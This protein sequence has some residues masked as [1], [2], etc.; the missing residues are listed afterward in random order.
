VKKRRALPWEKRPIGA[1]VAHLAGLAY[2][3][4]EQSVINTSAS[5]IDLDEFPLPYRKLTE[6]Y[7]KKYFCGWM[8]PLATV[9]TSKGCP[10]R[11]SFCAL[12]KIS[13]GK[14]FQRKP[15][16]IVEEL[17]TIEEEFI[18]FS[19]DESMVNAS[20]WSARRWC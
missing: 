19:D 17:S 11:C 10:F 14:Y 12:W 3:G 8:K 2:K 15:E 1:F 20:R 5:P 13:E 7:R 6:R 18:F 16:R 9:R 4:G